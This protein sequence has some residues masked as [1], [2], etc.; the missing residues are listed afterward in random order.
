MLPLHRPILFT[1]NKTYINQIGYQLKHLIVYLENDLRQP[2]FE[3]GWGQG[4]VYKSTL[5]FALGIR[6]FSLPPLSTRN[7]KR[8]IEGG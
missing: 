5:F 1:E 8:Y 7:L 3:S 4:K 6:F 2:I